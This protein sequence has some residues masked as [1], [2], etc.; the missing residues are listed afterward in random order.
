M[1]KILVVLLA[2]LVTGGLFA[3]ITFTGDVKSGLNITQSSDEYNADN[4]PKV[5]CG[6]MVMVSGSTLQGHWTLMM[7]IA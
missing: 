6:M 2:I 4:D 5:G 1:K 7:I 3:Q